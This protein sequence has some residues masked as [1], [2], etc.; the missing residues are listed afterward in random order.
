[1]IDRESNILGTQ[2]VVVLRYPTMEEWIGRWWWGHTVCPNLLH[3][4]KSHILSFFFP[5]R[6]E[7]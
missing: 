4:K 2:G 7:D 1:M 6:I 5:K 3:Y